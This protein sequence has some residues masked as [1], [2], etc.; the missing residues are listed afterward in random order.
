MYLEA[1]GRAERTDQV[2]RVQ[3]AY[4]SNYTREGVVDLIQAL[5]N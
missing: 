4:A 5:R 3:A 1:I 2:W